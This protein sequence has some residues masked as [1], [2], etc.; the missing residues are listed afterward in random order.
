MELKFN[1]QASDKEKSTMAGEVFD[2]EGNKTIEI[3]GSWQDEVF[4]RDNRTKQVEKIF[5]EV[6]M[7]QNSHLQYYFSKIAVMLN[8]LKDEM[9]GYVS[10]TDTRMRGDIRHFE[11]G[12][13]D[14]AEKVKVDIEIQ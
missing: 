8:D 7:I 9:V 6:P 13:I 4:M 5:K 2:A 1:Q 11:H 10:P 12:D 3:Y 14:Q